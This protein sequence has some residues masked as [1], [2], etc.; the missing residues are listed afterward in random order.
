MTLALNTKKWFRNRPGIHTGSPVAKRRSIAANTGLMKSLTPTVA[1]LGPEGTFAQLAAQKRFGADAKLIPALS[2]A[3]VFELVA[4]KR[5]AL[6]IVPIE[7]SSGGTIYETVDRLVDNK[8]K[9]IVQEALSLNVRLALL[10]KDKKNIR[11]VYSHFAPLFHCKAWLLKKFPGVEL[12]E[13]ASTATAIQKAAATPRA[14]AIGNRAA[15]KRYGLKVLEFPIQQDIKNVTQFFVLGRQRAVS[16]DNCKTTIVFTLPNHPG[17]L[18]DF[19]TPLKEDGVNLTRILSRPIIGQPDAYIF[20][21]DI[22]G[23]P[24]QSN[25]KSALQKAGR[26]A[27]TIKNIGSYPVRKTY[28]T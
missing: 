1:Y 28:E 5:A 9:L 22:A 12:V 13:Q 6:G 11:V 4:K 24:G 18:Y 3:D 7:N 14:A 8:N 20:L 10:G 19:L 27:A 2:I 26:V 16:K 15:A 17:S 21:A 25:V 23:T